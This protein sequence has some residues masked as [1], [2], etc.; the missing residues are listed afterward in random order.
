M[1]VNDDQNDNRCP[2]NEMTIDECHAYNNG[3][4]MNFMI[5]T[6]SDL[7]AEEIIANETP[8]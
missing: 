6:E 7:K 8:R 5:C 1:R 2:Y 4:C 3:E